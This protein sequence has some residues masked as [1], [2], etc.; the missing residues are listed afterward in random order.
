MAITIN[1]TTGIAG[2]DG[3]AS[4]PAL[5]GADTNTGVFFPAA[6]TVAVTTGGAE[7]MRVD[8]SGNV[9]IGTSSPT[10]YGTYKTLEV[11]GTGGGLVQVGT[12][13]ATAAYL[14]QDGTNAG[15]NNV[16]NGVMTF[17]TNNS[18]R[19]RIES[20]GSFLVGTTTADPIGVKV[21]GIALN[22]G[23]NQINAMSNGQRC[24]AFGR[25]TNTGSL[26]DF[27]YFGGSLVG[28]G[29]INTNGTN[30]T[31]ATSSDYR[32]KEDIHPMTGALAKI[33][34]LKPCTYKWKVDGSD[35]E[36]FIAHELA[37]V[38][39]DAV[40]GEKDAVNEDGSIKAQSIDTSFLVATLTAAIQEQ[41][42]MIDTMKQEI[43]ALKGAQA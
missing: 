39:P 8:S 19:A 32:L 42:A 25:Y 28:V 36:G 34:A 40:I 41:Q 2:V 23:G 35:G 12:G 24:G 16:A 14:F 7:R 31:Y 29:N 26:I 9:G 13:A 1:G 15:F 17:G 18:E 20:G 33:A 4:T 27:F 21:Q 11:R 37:E 22:G 38:V 6:D 43:A 5:Q 30:T 3:S 10:T